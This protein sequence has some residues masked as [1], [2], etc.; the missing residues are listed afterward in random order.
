MTELHFL[1]IHSLKA[2][3]ALCQGEKWFFGGKDLGH[4]KLF[5]G[6]NSLFG[7]AEKI[8]MCF[9]Q[10]WCVICLNYEQMMIDK[11]DGVTEKR[12]FLALTQGRA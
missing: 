8:L 2:G 5:T 1:S 11:L 12:C 10:Y 7:D 4:K 6:S 9:L 3:I